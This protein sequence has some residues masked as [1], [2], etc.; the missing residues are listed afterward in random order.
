MGPPGAGS[1]ATGGSW[2]GACWA[3]AMLVIEKN[4]HATTPAGT[5]AATRFD[6]YSPKLVTRLAGRECERDAS[7]GLRSG[8]LGPT[9][10]RYGICTTRVNNKMNIAQRWCGARVPESNIVGVV[11]FGALSMGRQAAMKAK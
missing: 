6:I 7:T 9:S 3:T 8:L 1:A 4:A 10:K 2:G 11:A 5:P